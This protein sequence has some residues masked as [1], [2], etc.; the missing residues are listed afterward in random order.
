M[1]SQAR[2]GAPRMNRRQTSPKRDRLLQSAQQLMLRQGYWATTIETICAAT[3][4]SKGVFF[5]YFNSKKALGRAA[6]QRFF[7]E[8]NQQLR[9]DLD[10]PPPD[11]LDCLELMIKGMTDILA[12]PNGPRGCLIAAFVLDTAE[13]EPALRRTCA[14][15]FSAWALMLQ[16]PLEEAIRMYCPHE[17]LSSEQLSYY[18]ICVIEGSLLM[19]RAQHATE[20]MNHNM[21]LLTGHIRQLMHQP[22]SAAEAANAASE[23]QLRRGA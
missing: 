12:S 19:A 13:I 3:K 20:V 15:Y 22:T 16:A 18:C 8:I 23:Q 4:L 1:E 7:D 10:P 2:K 17:G 11:P 6:L 21:S 5:H 9:K 14:K